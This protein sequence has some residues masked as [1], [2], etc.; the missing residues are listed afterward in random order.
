MA[1]GLKKQMWFVVLMVRG[2]V[3]Y[4]LRS[5]ITD[6]LEYKPMHF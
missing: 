1:L 2:L 4:N 3:N 6:V 5:F